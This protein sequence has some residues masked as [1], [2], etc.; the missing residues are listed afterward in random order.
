MR[1]EE[2]AWIGRQNLSSP[3]LELGSSTLHF[4]T[5]SQPHIDQLIHAPLR[6]KGFQVVHADLKSAEGVDIVGDFADLDVQER[7]RAV[8]ARSIL[9]C[10]LLEHIID[11]SAMARLLDSLLEPGGTMIVTVP[12]SVPFHNDPIDTYFRPT[13]DELAALFPDYAV[14]AAAIVNSTSY[15]QDLIRERANLPLTFLKTLWRLSKVWKG[16][17]MYLHMNHRLLWLFRPYRTSCVALRKP[18]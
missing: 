10:N 6:E 15:G 9:C 14:T 16:W 3:V 13:P 12:F 18:G 2:A 17:R 11:R 5:T 4:R 1:V 8:G 7:L